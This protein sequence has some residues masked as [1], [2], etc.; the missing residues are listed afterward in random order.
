MPVY[1]YNYI[2]QKI[3]FGKTEM[4]LTKVG[5]GGIP[6]QRCTEKEGIELVK[7]AVNSGINWIDT[8]NAY[9]VSEG[10]IGN[11]VQ[12]FDR[13]SIYIFTKSLARDLD[14]L[15]MHIENSL[16]KLKTSYIDLFQI[17]SVSDNDN[18]NRI[19]ENRILEYLT[20]LKTGGTVRHIGASSHKKEILLEIM[21]REEIEAVQFP[22]NFVMEDISL[23]VVRKARELDQGFIAMKPFGGGIFDDASVCV[24]FF[25]QYPDI[26]IDPGFQDIAEV[27][28]V[29][30]LAE[31]D[32][33]LTDRDKELIKKAVRETGTK[34]CRRCGYC[35]P[36]ENGVNIVTIMN[37]ESFI[38]R[39]PKDRLKTTSWI[40]DHAKTYENCINCGICET[41]CPYELP[42]MN[43][44]KE[45]IEKYKKA[46][47]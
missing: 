42:I 2:M 24:P 14:T 17:H 10:V 43:R 22:F 29:I 21:D 38:K 18:W 37:L 27:R 33:K 39:F 45:S 47:S 13:S 46:V 4:M 9:G 8:A 5:F 44:M 7:Y 6:V 32:R 25:K 28:E 41:R 12:E 19:K 20:E 23:D 16:L 3:R 36:C 35:E 15:K 31:Q 1:I 11:A 26:V 40:A 34:F 30:E